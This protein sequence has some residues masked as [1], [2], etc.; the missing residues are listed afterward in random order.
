M[1]FLAL[2]IALGLLQYWGSAGPVHRDEWFRDVVQRFADSG[3]MKELQVALAVLLPALLVYWVLEFMHG[4]LLGMVPLAISVL[5]L[6]PDTA[7][8]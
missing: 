1:K 5:V 2:V 6:L 8:T 3:L 4:W 7:G